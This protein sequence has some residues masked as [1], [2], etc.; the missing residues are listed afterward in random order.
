[1]S[2]SV[3]IL[4][5]I[6]FLQVGL[7]YTGQMQTKPRLLRNMDIISLQHTEFMNMNTLHKR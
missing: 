6:S 2:Y 4:V 3:N 7:G 5:N 1:M